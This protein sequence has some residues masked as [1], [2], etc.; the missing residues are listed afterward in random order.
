VK[1]LREGDVLGSSTKCN[2]SLQPTDPKNRAVC[3]YDGIAS[4]REYILSIRSIG[5]N[6]SPSKVCMDITFEAFQTIRLVS[7]AAFSHIE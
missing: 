3:V 6:P 2:L 1:S 7:D 5:L 4:T